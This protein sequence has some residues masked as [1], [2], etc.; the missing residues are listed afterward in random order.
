MRR[1]AGTWWSL[2]HPAESG[3]NG[4][5]APVPTGFESC[6]RAATDDVLATDIQSRVMITPL[7]ASSPST[8]AG[9]GC[10][11]GGH[12]PRSGAGPTVHQ[13]D[14]DTPLGRPVSVGATGP[15]KRDWR[16]VD[17]AKHLSPE[18]SAHRAA[19]GQRGLV[20]AAEP[21][22]GGTRSAGGHPVGWRAYTRAATAAANETAGT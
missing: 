22:A 17:R 19:D 10:R 9:Q 3:L 4:T 11:I 13:G 18:I 5:D 2:S 15:P 16:R 1:L 21:S 12:P 6:C 8:G 7:S 14:R 20:A